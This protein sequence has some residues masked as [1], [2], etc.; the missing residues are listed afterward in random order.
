M[1]KK[2]KKEITTLK[3]GGVLT[4]RLVGRVRTDVAVP[5]SM[6][7][8]HF[9]KEENRKISSSNMISDNFSGLNTIR[10]Y[11]SAAVPCYVTS[12]SRNYR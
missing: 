7:Y 9:I 2:V 5:H 8:Q 3:E 12:A 11:C 1:K 4:I 10:T 6:I